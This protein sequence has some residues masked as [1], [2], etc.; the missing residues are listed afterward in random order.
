MSVRA[1]QFNRKRRFKIPA[2]AGL[3]RGILNGN[4]ALGGDKSEKVRI[5][6]FG[7]ILSIGKKGMN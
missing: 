5:W 3:E 1:T 2:Q 4:K 6:D 7:G